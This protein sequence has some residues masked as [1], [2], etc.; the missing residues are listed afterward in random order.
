MSSTHAKDLASGTLYESISASTTTILVYVGEGSAAS[1]TGV[2]PDVPFYASIMP[3]N[4]S[5]GVPNSLDSEIVKV[6]A[7]GNDQLGNVSL[8]VVRAQRGT[9]SKAFTAGAI[10]T[11]AVYAEDAVLLGPDGT[12]ESPSP[13]I[14]SGDIEDGAVTTAKLAN[15][16]V[17]NAK[18]ADGTVKAPK[19]DYDS[20][21]TYHI[22]G[23]TTATT[24]SDWEN[25]VLD[26]T[27]LTF[28]NAD[29]GGIYEI[30][31]TLVYA[32]P[33]VNLGELN[34]GFSTSGC[35]VLEG[36]MDYQI[37]NSAGGGRTRNWRYLVQATSTSIIAKVV[38][39]TSAAA[40]VT[41]GSGY[42]TI[43]RVG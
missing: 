16:A 12:T 26:N 1:I 9:T 4:P 3:S 19:I 11:S 41:I 20:T 18:I 17:T 33:N 39:I 13:W 29:V 40:T 15:N 36:I 32:H 7:V 35:S 24:T 23:S 8:A 28:S 38:L 10:V 5:A 27:T 14:Q 6:T 31:C 21:G 2:W 37:G 30:E 25:K 43:R 34:F 42:T 22:F